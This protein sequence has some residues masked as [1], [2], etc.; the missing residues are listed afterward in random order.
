M[1]EVRRA[2]V[3]ALG[4]GVLL[5]IP[6]GAAAND[7]SCTFDAPPPPSPRLVRPVVDGLTLNVLL[8]SD[9]ATSGRSYPVLYL[10]HGG[11]YN[12]N[13]WLDQS[14]V[15]QFTRPFTGDQAAIVVMPDGG[16]MGFYTDWHD[17]TQLWESYHIRRVIPYVDEHFR[18][19]ADGA[20]RAVAGFS[21]GG[22]GAL[23][24]AARYPEL[25]A[26]VGSF[27]G[28]TDLTFP[29]ANY[30][31]AGATPQY[32]AGSPGP[33]QGDAPA[34]AYHA[35]DDEGSGCQGGGDQFG[36]RVF[37]PVQWHNHNPTDIGSN[38]RGIGVYLAA[39]TGI[40]C[41]PQDAGGSPS[42]LPWVEPG[43][44]ETAKR[45][46]TALTVGGVEHE[47]D[48]YL[49][50]LHT[51]LYAQRDLHRFWPYML[52]HF[53]RT[54]PTPFDYRTAD[55][56]FSVRGWSFRADPARAVE[57]LEVRNASAAGFNLTGSGTETVVT[58]G[59]YTP[60]Q[61]VDV[62]GAKPAVAT[63]DTQG[64][65]RLAVDLG[66]AHQRNQFKRLGPKPVWHTRVVTLSPR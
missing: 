49:C 32:D 36:D 50:G 15:E 2:V 11:E 26:A 21:L 38:L 5:V 41:G 47:T 29:E 44:R 61:Q 4:I 6:G 60:G 59:A 63:A 54:L 33:V 23:N 42:L 51:M 52:A 64:R 30:L 1:R 65:V 43:V 57:F 28:L 40:P 12:E 22:L 13:T 46:D 31:G 24:Y 19:L 45:L 55:K 10:F 37:D 35:P 25:F 48:F 17:G 56:D 16:P 18:T 58:P 3:A 7:S 53:G 34:P 27:S 8:P 39:G 20:H 62:T 9:Y 66:P 14:D